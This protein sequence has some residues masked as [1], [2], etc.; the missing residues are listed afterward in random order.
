MEATQSTLA[1]S[2]LAPTD[3][4]HIFFTTVTGI[5]PPSIDARLVNRMSMR[6]D[7]KRTPIFGLGCLGGAPGIPRAADYFW[8]FP[9]PTPLFLSVQLSSPTLQLKD[10]SIP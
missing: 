9:S 3:I 1:Q 10:H 8:P 5:A 6:T 7:I 4:D 2:T